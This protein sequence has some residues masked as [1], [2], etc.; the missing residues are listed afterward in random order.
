MAILA[1][2]T[3]K[4]PRKYLALAKRASLFLLAILVASS[5]LQVLVPGAP[6]QAKTYGEMTPSEQAASYTYYAVLGACVESSM[7]GDIDLSVGS[8]GNTTP[9]IGSNTDG[10]GSWFNPNAPWGITFTDGHHN[11]DN[12]TKDALQL[13]GWGSDYKDFL[14]DIGYTYEPNNSPRP[15]WHG[16]E[17]S[18]DGSI[19]RQR[20]ESAVQSQVYKQNFPDKPP[21]GA[22]AWYEISF[23]NFFASCKAKDLGLYDSLD[24]DVKGRVDSR[25]TEGDTRYTS[26]FMY[27]TTTK[28]A[29]NHGFSYTPPETGL[30]TIYGY[31]ASGQN[32]DNGAWLSCEELGKRMSDNAPAMRSYVEDNPDYIPSTNTTDI[33]KICDTNP[34]D[35]ACKDDSQSSCVV[36]GI[37][38]II[39]PVVNFIAAITDAAYGFVSSF[40]VVQPLMTTDTKSGLFGAWSVMRNI[41]NVA[42]G[43]AFLIIIFSQVSSIGITNYGIKKMLPRLIAA[44]ILV[45]ISYWIC[46]VAVDLSNIVGASARNIFE[47]VGANIQSG[48]NTTQIST[49]EGWVGVAGFILAGG[50][51]TTVALYIGLSALLPALIAVLIAIVTVVLVLVLRQALIILLVAIAPLAFVA[52]LLPNTEGLFKKWKGLLTTLLLMYPIIAG[53]F[54]ASALA[55]SIIM[56]SATSQGGDYVIAIQIMGAA[57][58]VIPL[59]I[60]PVV[61]KTA[62]GVLNRFAGYVNNPNK[63]PFDR[64]RKGADDIRKRQEG[65]REI[66]A[67]NNG[68]VFGGSRFRRRAERNAITKGIEGEVS[69]AQAGYIAEQAMGVDAFRNQLA[70]GRRVGPGRTADEAATQ[71]ALANAINVQTKLEADEVT[72]ASAIIKNFDRDTLRT[73]S[74]GGAAEGLDA[75]RSLAVKTAAMQKVLDSQDIEGTN[76]LLDQASSGG[77]DP[78]TRRAFAEVLERSSG[79]PSYVN[80]GAIES[81]KQG[82][83]MANSTQ[84]TVNAINNNT[85][86]P[87][88]IA[89]SSKDEMDHV[90]NIAASAVVPTDNTQIIAAAKTALS[91]PQYSGKIAKQAEAVKNIS[92][93]RF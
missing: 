55:S 91:V 12:L 54:G 92:N 58:A 71:R 39:C 41:A 27:N 18:G 67:L 56:N 85:Y 9:S 48:P 59:F 86:S 89:A 42:F 49:G 28:K 5:S 47:S 34:N 25:A 26:Y 76:H 46:A 45:N 32:G 81:Y 15:R 66:R 38:W 69:R 37:G 64:M 50:L 75:S 16:P 1:R 68:R 87:D 6:A 70:G 52:F 93:L 88:K 3:K 2:K 21:I 83:N 35:P 84:L 63:G 90:L 10:S 77:M 14:S 20:F 8:G 22:A 57:V 43:I 72:A 29:E 44:A 40:L 79:R 23:N 73:L 13:W 62:G 11:C 4:H 61:M 78:A 51:A 74:Q 24:S 7:Y 82:E 65:R 60:T 36:D 30:V 17:P 80:M 19:R 31:R 33:A 53:I